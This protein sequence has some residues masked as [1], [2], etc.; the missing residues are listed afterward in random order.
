MSFDCL[1]SIIPN[2]HNIFKVAFICWLVIDCSSFF[3]NLYPNS[4]SSLILD[5]S[6][7]LI[8]LIIDA[9]MISM[10]IITNYEHLNR[11]SVNLVDMGAT[12][13]PM[14]LSRRSYHH[15]WSMGAMTQGYPRYSFTHLGR[16]EGWIG[17]TAWGGWE[18]CWYDLHGESNPGCLHGRWFAQHKS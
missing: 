11:G 5:D 16:M 1:F 17:L 18:I 15:W 12:Y 7:A 4:S 14:R 13:W 10:E 3:I 8:A 2:V 6:I 9:F